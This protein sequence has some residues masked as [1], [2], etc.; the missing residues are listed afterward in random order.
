MDY[1]KEQKFSNLK[2]DNLSPQQFG[3]Q[4]RKV[5]SAM[6]QVMNIMK[7]NLMVVTMTL[8]M[9]LKIKMAQVLHTKISR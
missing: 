9:I 8:M 3:L 5:I 1:A 2:P 6:V 7:T 4:K